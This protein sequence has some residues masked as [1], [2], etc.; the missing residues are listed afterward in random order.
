MGYGVVGE[1]GRLRGEW[2]VT[3]GRGGG[4][5][6]EGARQGNTGTW[7]PKKDCSPALPMAAKRTG[8]I[9][10]GPV[11]GEVEKE[12]QRCCRDVEK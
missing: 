2:R 7:D 3:E 6:V 12:A 1:E 9:G 10:M 8:L 11:N 5:M 4:R